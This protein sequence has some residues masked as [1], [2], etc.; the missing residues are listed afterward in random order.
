MALYTDLVWGRKAKLDRAELNRR[1]KLISDAIEALRDFVPDWKAEVDALRKVGLERIDTAL[2]P[3]YEQIIELANLGALLWATSTSSVEIG[4]GPKTFIIP[5]NKRDSFAPTPFLIVAA[6]SDYNLSMTG[7]LSSYN[8]ETGELVILA[9]RSTGSGTYANWSIGPVATTDDLEA[10]RD[11]VQ[12]NAATASSKAAEAIAARDAA[13][14]HKTAAQTA[15][16]GAET[17]KAGADATLADFGTKWYMDRD[18]APEGAPIGAMYLDTSTTP[19]VVKVLTE[20]GWNPAVTVSVGGSRQQVYVA[21]EG[22]TGPFTVDGGF[23]AGFVYAN[24]VL[25]ADGHGVT[26]SPGTGEF[27]FDE[28]RKAGDVIVFSGYL[29]NDATDI[30]TKSEADARFLSPMIAQA[31]TDAQKLQAR[32][33]ADARRDSL[34]PIGANADLNTYTETGDYKQH[35]SVDADNG[36][37]YPVPI[38]GLLRVRKSGTFV[39]QTYTTFA[40]HTTDAQDR[41]YIRGFY[42]DTWSPWKEIT[43]TVS[44]TSDQTLA[45]ADRDRARGN[46]QAQKDVEYTNYM[47]LG[48]ALSGNRDVY[49]DFHST[50]DPAAADYSARIHRYQGV[51]GDWGFDLVG[52]GRY[53]FT[54]GTDFLRDGNRV[55]HAGNDGPGTGLDADTVDGFNASAFPKIWGDTF[56]GVMAHRLGG[57]WGQVRF[58]EYGWASGYPGW[59]FYMDN[60]AAASFYS[61]NPSD[62][63]YIGRPLHMKQNGDVFI[64]GALSKASGTFLIDHPLDPENRDLA[65]GFVEAP[66]YDLIYRGTVALVDGRATVDIDVASNMNPGTFEA[67]TTNAVV[68]SL[69]NQSGFAR[70]RPGVITGGSFEVICEDDTSTDTVSWVVIAERNDA[71]VKHMDDNCD[72]D[73]RFIPE[74]EK[75]E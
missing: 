4:L 66:R 74:R 71:F 44:Y 42:M 58:T 16:T 40:A 15:R 70:L 30:H 1:A 49:Y 54:G 8:R 48:A 65:H 7:I 57:A 19:N 50:D 12:A 63:T 34:I 69:Q 23:S 2:K 18:T 39:Y 37:N 46:I 31:F 73:G 22:Q 55:W 59:A 6:D 21:T 10:L 60:D 33:N 36:T 29:A 56:T 17:A 51:H 52:Q 9:E 35:L 14:T 45:A 64:G 24:G 61:Y 20:T 72:A 47:E 11:Q 28:G 41:V 75:P 13:E 5:A 32:Q 3:A 53:N 25:I 38:A 26:L 27:T 62:G 67:L 43:G 68:T